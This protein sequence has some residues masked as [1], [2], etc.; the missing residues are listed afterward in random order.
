MLA[1]CCDNSRV[2]CVYA[3]LSLLVKCDRVEF[4]GG[5]E[6][7]AGLLMGGGSLMVSNK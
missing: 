4:C 2:V 7:V 1:Q 6:V 5:P 3:E